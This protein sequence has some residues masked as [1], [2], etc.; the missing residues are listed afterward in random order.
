MKGSREPFHARMVPY[1]GSTDHHAF[2]PAR[3]GVPATSLTNWPDEYIHST[4]DD[5]ENIDATQLERNA[6]VATAVALYFASL[7]DDDV[8]RARG[9]RGRARPA[10]GS[11]PTSRRRSSTSR[12]AAPAD[13]ASGLRAPH[14]I[15]CARAT[16]KEAGAARLGPPPRGARDARGSSRRGPRTGWQSSEAEAFDTLERTYTAMT[17]QNPPN[18]DLAKEERAMAAKVFAPVADLGAVEDALET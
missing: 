2:T 15:S 8:A 14:A 12:S 7:K 1:F 16:A 3:I 9:L 18:L 11:P 6:V 17:G 4:G 13:R 10:P 5:L